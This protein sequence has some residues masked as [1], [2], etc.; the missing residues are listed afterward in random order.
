LMRDQATARG[1]IARMI[2]NRNGS[3]E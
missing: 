2:A 3:T 1:I